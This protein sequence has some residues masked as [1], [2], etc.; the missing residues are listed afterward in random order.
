MRT[1]GDVVRAVRFQQAIESSPDVRQ[2]VDDLVHAGRRRLVAV[3]QPRLDHA[4]TQVAPEQAAHRL[5][6]VGAQH[7]AE[8]VVQLETGRRAR[9]LIH[10]SDDVRATII[11]SSSRRF[12]QSPAN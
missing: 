9:R 6:V 7:P 4:S 12:S 1:D 5:R 10:R 11:H 8:V 3:S 2:P